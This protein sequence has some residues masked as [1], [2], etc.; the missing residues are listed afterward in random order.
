[1]TLSTAIRPIL[2]PD[3]WWI[4]APLAGVGLGILTNLAQGV[5]PGASNQIANSGA[6]WCVPAFAAGALVAGGHPA[7]RKPVLAGLCTTIGLVVGYYGY[8]E[9]GRS[10]MGSPF[11]PLVWLAMALISGPLFGAAGAWWRHGRTT[12]RRVVALAALS[13]VFGMESIQYAWVLHYAPQAWTCAALLVAIPLL[14]A[15]QHR[16][17]ALTLLTALAFSAIAYAVIELPL[18]HMPA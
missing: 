18:Q 10:G 17:R 11:W 12:G 9:F 6:V 2:G 14:M 8:A 16:E 15:R 7:L 13:G 3:R 5:L 4:S 1:M